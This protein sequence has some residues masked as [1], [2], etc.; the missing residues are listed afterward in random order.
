MKP[1]IPTLTTIIL[2]GCLPALA[3]APPKQIESTQPQH[4]AQTDRSARRADLRDVAKLN[5]LARR[6]DAAR[7]SRDKNAMSL[8]RSE[9]RSCAMIELQKVGTETVRASADVSRDGAEIRSDHRRVIESASLSGHPAL[10]EQPRDE[11]RDRR[12]D[13]PQLTVQDRRL[14]IAAEL[15]NM[16]VTTNDGQNVHERAL[17]GELINLAKVDGSKETHEKAPTAVKKP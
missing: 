14:E 5:E 13:V 2:A 9:L 16:P 7:S 3:Q 17:I 8:V 11:A 15:R 1:T 4:S 6:H 10:D 12:N